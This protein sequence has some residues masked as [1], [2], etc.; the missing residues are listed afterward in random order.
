MCCQDRKQT[1]DTFLNFAI[2]G[3][4][5]NLFHLQKNLHTEIIKF[6]LLLAN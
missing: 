4:Y 3:T 6:L 1:M 5:I 2:T